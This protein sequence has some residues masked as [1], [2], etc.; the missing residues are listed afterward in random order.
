MG[1]KNTF[2]AQKRRAVYQITQG[3][4]FYCGLPLAPDRGD[5]VDAHGRDWL[6]PQHRPQMATDHQLPT[7]RGGSDELDNLNPA[8]GK[9]NSRK[10]LST[11]DE[12]RFRLGVTGGGLPYRFA[13]D[14]PPVERDYIVVVSPDFV[15]A[16]VQHNYPDAYGRRPSPHGWRR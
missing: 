11:V 14:P 15:R 4:C 7:Q 8:C 6:V 1:F 3:F 16:M 10:N 2:G 13:F 12:F 9:C 5:L